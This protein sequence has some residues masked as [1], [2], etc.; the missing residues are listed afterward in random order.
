M[1]SRIFSS[2]KEIWS[3]SSQEDT[4]NTST[5]QSSNSETPEKK[6]WL[7]TFKK[8]N[9]SRK[10]STSEKTINEESN[11]NPKLGKRYTLEYKAQPKPSKIYEKILL[12]ELRNES[13]KNN[14][15]VREA[16]VQ[17]ELNKLW[18]EVMEFL[19]KKLHKEEVIE[20]VVIKEVTKHQK[21]IDEIIEE[22]NK[23]DKIYGQDLLGSF[24]LTKEILSKYGITEEH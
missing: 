22:H 12:R 4:L 8:P 21:L 11:V 24:G 2:I 9:K 17:S 14:G 16:L 6:E 1:F 10:R 5:N 19:E 13:K 7:I 23:D 18:E 15:E 20:R 3:K